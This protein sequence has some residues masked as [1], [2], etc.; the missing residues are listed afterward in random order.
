MAVSDDL[1]CD[2]CGYDLRA[3]PAD[4]VCPECGMAVEDSIELAKL[5]VR[6]R[7][8][9]SD[10]R[11]RR[12][13]VAG[14][15]LLAL[16]PA[17]DVLEQIGWSERIMLPALFEGGLRP[18]S[19][20][21]FST[22]WTLPYLLYCTGFALLL[23]PESERRRGRFDWTR[24]WGMIGLSLVVMLGF[25]E[26]MIV[27]ALVGLGVTALF[28]TLPLSHQPEMA[29]LLGT[30]SIEL[31]CLPLQ[32]GTDQSFAALLA[33]SGLVVIF[34]CVRLF[35]A[36]RSIGPWWLAA[37]LLS[38]LVI[39][40]TLQVVAAALFFVEHPRAEDL[41]IAP[42]FVEPWNLVFEIVTLYYD[43]MSPS[44]V[45]LHGMVEMVKWFG[46]VTFATCL[47]VAQI[48]ARWTRGS[49]GATGVDA[50]GLLNAPTS[51]ASSSRVHP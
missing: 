48:H 11:W 13:M 15:W 17:M 38:L 9:D 31:L 36:L 18:L 20:T 24:R 21:F 12:R 33:I 1:H 39:P 5:P 7:W 32:G 35:D 43:A 29:E 49:K 41:P 19:E 47:T 3:T 23:T 42:F 37:A 8:R 27:P 16:I 14:A 4:G 2:R 28:F 22:F 25:L 51:P 40:M 6:P 34:A 10:P 46:I 50:A 26:L 44:A 45:T 30:V